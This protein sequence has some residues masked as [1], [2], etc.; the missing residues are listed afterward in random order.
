M[1]WFVLIGLVSILGLSLFAIAQRRGELARMR[2]VL[3]ER[4]EAVRVGAHK[5]QLQHPLIDLSRCLGCATC[6]AA[7]PEDGILEIVHGQAVVVR[8]ARCQGI[9]ACERECPVGA[10]QVTLAD[11]DQRDD[12]PC[13]AENL[14]AVG[15]EGLFLAGE[16]TAHALIKTA[17]EQGSAVAAEV[18]GR[19]RDATNGHAALD[20]DLV[21]VGAGPAGLACAL[22]AKRQGLRTVILDQEATA[23]GTVAKYPR[24]KLVLTQPVDLPLMG[25]LDR[26]EYTREELV[27]LWE[28]A[29]QDQQLAF[30]PREEFV[31]LENL[32]D[33]SFRVLTKCD[34]EIH[35]WEAH[36]VCLAVGRRGTPRKLG[37]AGE[38]LAKVSYSLL[39]AGTHAGRR[40]LV[41]G[42]GDS[43]VEAALA[44]AAQ[45][46]AEVTLSYRRGEFF[47]LKSRNEERLAEARA[48]NRLRVLTDSEV[49]TI[50]ADTV[51]IG[52]VV[53]N[54]HGPD[55]IERISLPNDDVFVLAGGVVPTQLLEKAGV[56]FDPSLRAPAE[57]IGEQGPGLLR[58]LQ[59]AFVLSLVAL[60]W[61]FFNFDYYALERVERPAH[62]KHFLLRPGMG[63]G[64]WMGII[65]IVLIVL[66]LAY[67][68]RRSPRFRLN[69]GS[70]QAW[71]TGHVATGVL[72]F[73]CATLHAAMAP[74]NT[75]GGHAWWALAT[76]LLTG[77]IGRYFYA[78]I[79]RA[80]N[81]HE[82]VLAEVRARLGRISE[83]WDQGQRRF[84][85][86]VRREVEGLVERGQ[87]SGNF[88]QRVATLV[89]G[90]RDLRRTLARLTA[91]GRREGIDEAQL[92]ETRRLARRAFRTALSVAR[93]EDLRAVL[94]TWRYLHRWVAL[95]MVIL[96]ALHV[97]TALTFGAK[98][99][100]GLR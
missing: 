16:V 74:R 47:R 28:R 61:A 55:G 27:E 36:A 25:S 91:E 76:L 73:L 84:R 50:G 72:A 6:V 82:L 30:A 97:F 45:A 57:T 48:A 29:V 66:N 62:T 51:E 58:A 90:Q 24:K 26:L 78:W 99:A 20:Y 71:M 87:W 4:E 8:G 33:G 52:R 13:L 67:L 83:E 69:L 63:F 46:G 17:I 59:M 100:E 11:L 95:L 93:Y 42:G 23:G 12:I 64:L 15:V 1:S 79:P 5:A 10:I 3:R 43:A 49:L 92:A 44:L 68:L 34:Q 39:D 14:E 37:V 70:L 41:V 35:A 19:R 31:E 38:E 77:A 7:C 96:V 80:A 86:R 94:N 32:P 88:L 40:S 89:R 9:A 56:S 53:K 21:I 18:A 81:G 65:S 60:A 98:I 22:E 85:E 2:G 54:T 75:P